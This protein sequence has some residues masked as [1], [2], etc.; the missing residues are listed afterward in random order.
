MS[1]QKVSLSD[2]DSVFIE[3]SEQ[4]IARLEKRLA[5]LQSEHSSPV[6]QGAVDQ[7][8]RLAGKGG[9]K[10]TH[11]PGSQSEWI[12]ATIRAHPVGESFSV[13]DLTAEVNAILRER[14]IPDVKKGLKQLQ[15]ASSRVRDHLMYLEPRGVVR[16]EE[17]GY[18]YTGESE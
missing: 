16:K 18:S 14:K 2:F 6:S 7:K 8:G 11:Q 15:V 10:I 1:E 4:K 13:A 5:E 12:T 17:S 9:T 3:S